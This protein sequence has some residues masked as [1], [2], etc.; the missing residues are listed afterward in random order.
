MY[1]MESCTWILL[2]LYCI[3]K[4]Y[5]LECRYIKDE[6]KNKTPFIVGIIEKN[7]T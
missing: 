4:T 5:H 7:F 6:I 2:L 1:I 3:Y